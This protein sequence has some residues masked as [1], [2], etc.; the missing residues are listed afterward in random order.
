MNCQSGDALAREQVTAQGK[1]QVLNALDST[2]AKL[3]EKLGESLK[4]VQKFDVPLAEAT[5][6]SLE[7]LQAYSIG[8]AERQVNDAKAL[9]SLKRAIEL[10]PDFASAYEALGVCYYNMGQAGLGRKYFTKAFELRDRVS[11]REKFVIAARY[12]EYVTGDLHK[13]IETYQL[14]AQSYPRSPTAH[15]NL[16]SLYGSIGQFERAI[17]DSVEA[18]KLEPD[19][20]A[21]YA[22]L[23][24]AYAA[25]ER[26]D[27][28]KQIYEQALARQIEDP[29]LRVNYFGVA[30]VNRDQ[31]EMDRLMA[32]SAGKP[33]AEDNFLAPNVCKSG[34]KLLP[35]P[36]DRRLLAGA[37]F[38]ARHRNRACDCGWEHGYRQTERA[39]AH[40]GLHA[41]R[42]CARSRSAE[43]RA[44]LRHVYLFTDMSDVDNGDP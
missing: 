40:D 23:V 31:V 25:L 15:A 42:D 36:V 14:W 21:H 8:T 22:N 17:P 26:Y 28:A 5:T 13:A 12:Y 24:L 11:E 41:V 20:G 2:T 1:E 30:F 39:D 32:W 38:D 27:D 35:A 16:G 4:S 9:P 44:L 19:A 18:V 10:D 6:A 43:W 34:E 29:I 7:A 3:R 37:Q 33:E